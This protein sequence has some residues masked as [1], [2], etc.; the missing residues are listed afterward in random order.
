M[1]T[2]TAFMVFLLISLPLFGQNYKSSSDRKWPES[3]TAQK[4]YTVSGFRHGV[5]FFPKVK[6]PQ[7]QYEAGDSLTF[8]KYHSANVIYTWLERWAANYP[9]LVDFY[10]VGKSY[11]GRPIVQITITNKKTGKDTDKPAAYFEGGR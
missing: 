9:D 6:Y 5:S 10:E 7:V 3:D 8:N 2:L 4:N 1:K 11:E